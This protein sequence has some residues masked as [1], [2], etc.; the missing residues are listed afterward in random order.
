MINFSLS[1]REGK[2]CVSIS[3]PHPMY[4]RFMVMNCSY[5]QFNNAWERYHDPAN[6]TSLLI[7]DAFYF[8]TEEER[9][10]LISGMLPSD[11][12]ELQDEE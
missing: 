4:P 1:Y 5:E 7:Q 10:F 8:L 6:F 11:W 9:E 2:L 3:P 12:A